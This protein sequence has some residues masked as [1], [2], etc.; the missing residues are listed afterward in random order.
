M[1]VTDPTR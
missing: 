1:L